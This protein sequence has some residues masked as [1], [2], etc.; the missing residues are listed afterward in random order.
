LSWFRFS[1]SH[2]SDVTKWRG[3]WKILPQKPFYLLAFGLLTGT[4]KILEINPDAGRFKDSP[5][6]RELKFIKQRQCAFSTSDGPELADDCMS[7]RPVSSC[8]IH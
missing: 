7:S 5:K 4:V 3:L 6:I 1:R 8:T 2:F